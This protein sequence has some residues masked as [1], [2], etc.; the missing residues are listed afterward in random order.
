MRRKL[1]EASKAFTCTGLATRYHLILSCDTTISTNL[2]S[3][4]RLSIVNWVVW[5]IRLVTFRR[6]LRM[7]KKGGERIVN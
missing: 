5:L 6:T 7:L 4:I 2:S 1:L 3:I